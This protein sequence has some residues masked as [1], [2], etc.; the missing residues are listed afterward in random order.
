MKQKL[1]IPVDSSG[2]LDEHFG[3]CKYF[4]LIDIDD[5]YIISREQVK[6]P[7][8]EPG[9]LP[10]WLAERGASAI[11]AGG[12][13]RKAIHLFN[14]YGINAYVGAP[15]LNAEELAERFLKGTLEFSANY[16]NH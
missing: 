9:L 5:Q 11:I 1:A 4:I 2:K 10:K 3:H 7:P 6:P 15:V 12:M 13:G 16:C 14:Q 8:H